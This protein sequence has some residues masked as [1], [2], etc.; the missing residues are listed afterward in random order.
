MQKLYDIILT[1][2][3]VGKIKKA[4]GTWG[5]AAGLMLWLVFAAIFF[6]YSKSG[7]WQNTFWFLFI[8][9][10]TLIGA[11]IVPKYQKQN[12]YKKIDHGSVVL[13]EVVGQIT[14]LQIVY[15]KV[16]NSYISLSFSFLLFLLL[17]FILFRVLDITKPLFIG[18][19]DRE[20]KGG[21]GVFLDDLVAGVFAGLIAII[22]LEV[23]IL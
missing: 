3:Y 10:F 4:P 9:F 13:D 21:L 14:A 8:L 22:L 23:I 11:R 12:N 20:L 17:S 7:L 19:I 15:I 1:F 5:S 16:F 18:R 2:F 6:I